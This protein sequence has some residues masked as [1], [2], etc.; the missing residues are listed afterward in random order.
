MAEEIPVLAIPNNTILQEELEDLELQLE[1]QTTN[2]S[3]PEENDGC[4]GL[5][6][7]DPAP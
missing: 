6:P 1:F 4:G 3:S 7:P 2:I 5:Q